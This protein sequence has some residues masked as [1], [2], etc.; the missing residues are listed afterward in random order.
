MAGLRVA[1]ASQLHILIGRLASVGVRFVIL[2]FACAPAIIWAQLKP[3]TLSAWDDYI[4]AAES[5]LRS[6]KTSQTLWIDEVPGRRK[7]VRS[8]EIVAAPMN[9]KSPRAV[10]HGVIHDWIG[11]IFIPEVSIRDVLAVIQDY[12]RY[13]EYYG[14]TI[15]YAKLL[16]RNGNHESFRVR[17]VRKA[18]FVTAVLDVEYEAQCY[19][20]DEHRWY[21]VA[22]STSVREIQNYSQPG[23]RILPADDGNGFVWRA[24]GILRLDERDGGVYVEQERIALSRTIPLSLRWLVEPFVER[25]SRDLVAGSLRKTRD[26]VLGG[27][28]PI[29]QTGMG[30]LAAKEPK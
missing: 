21:S 24:F 23:E 1:S 17:Y 26:A 20:I 10:P 30:Y 27:H 7:R 4:D 2:L 19:R 25:L 15:R 6:D 5:R 9:A 11:A 18:L 16:N 14:P 13:A 28:S 29:S 3:A 8:G 22:R 12:D